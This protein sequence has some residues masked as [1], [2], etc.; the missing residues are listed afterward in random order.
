MIAD[1]TQEESLS[2]LRKVEANK[3]LGRPPNA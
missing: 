3:Y 2:M 1:M